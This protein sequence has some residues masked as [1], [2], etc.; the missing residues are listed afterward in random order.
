M[1]KKIKITNIVLLIAGEGKRISKFSKDPKCLLM[2]NKISILERNL[3]IWYKLGFKKIIV[4]LG[5]KYQSIEKILKKFET[6]L[7]INRVYNN[8]F[9]NFGSCYSLYLA[10][11]KCNSNVIF[12]DGDVVYDAKILKEYIRS[13]KENSIL[14]GKGSLYNTECAKIVAKKDLI[15]RIIEKRRIKRN[16]LI[17]QKF[18]GEMIGIGKISKNRIKS[19]IKIF[20]NN[21]KDKNSLL[22]WDTGFDKFII[23]TFKTNFYYTKNNNWVEIDLLSDLRVANRIKFD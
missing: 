20:K 8:K 7:R 21:I 23:K 11:K 22:N 18:I 1:D 15:T 3:N 13:N 2:V 19:Y 10:M 16:E 12:F 4:V 6:K 14:V 17:N 9:K 5:Y